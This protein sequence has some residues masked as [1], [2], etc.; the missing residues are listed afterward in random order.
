MRFID[1]LRPDIRSVVL[2]QRPSDLDTASYLAI[3]QEQGADP[4]RRLDSKKPEQG[5]FSKPN[6]RGALPLPTPPRPDKP[7]ALASTEEKKIYDSGQSPEEKLA[8]LR[9]FRRAKGLC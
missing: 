4:S 9:A 5:Y 2:V 6:L 3:L 7:P 8:A 1:G